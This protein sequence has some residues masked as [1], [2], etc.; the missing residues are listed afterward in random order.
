MNMFTFTITLIS[1]FF[2][3]FLAGVYFLKPSLSNIDNKIYKYILIL[4]FFQITLSLIC[5]IT[6]YYL[7]YNS[8]MM[9]I[10]DISARFFCVTQ[11]M[12]YFS[13]MLY[14][15]IITST[16]D[17]KF[18]KIVIGTTKLGKRIR[19]LL[20]LV[21]LI[22]IWITPVNYA[23]NSKGILV[24]D[25]GRTIIMFYTLIATVPI[26]VAYLVKQRKHY[27]IKKIIPFIIIIGFQLSAFGISKIDNSINMYP[28]TITL[29]SYLMFHTI[30]NPD[31]QLITK[32]QEAKDKAE[33]S[34]KEKTDFLASMSHEL[35]TP[36]N[37]IIGL[38]SMIVESNDKEQ[39]INDGKDVLK[40]ANNLQ[41]L[42]DG[43]LD[44]NNLEADNLVLEEEIYRP[45]FLFEDLIR[46]TNI[47]L[48]DKDIQLR[49]N[50]SSRIPSKLYGDREKLKRVINNLLTNAVKY[51]EKGYVDFNIDCENIN[52]I[53]NLKI[54]VRDTG[55]GIQE[56][57]K[58][59]LFQKF[60]RLESDKDSDISGTGLGLAVTKS[61]LDIMNGEIEV[62][63][64]FGQG[65]TFTIHLSQKIEEKEE[66]IEIL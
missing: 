31:I 55:R 13:L 34:N 56:D 66:E 44:I 33:K 20:I 12:W 18:R 51:T 4:D 60:Y 5:L 17:S 8:I 23:I 41:E 21:L 6:A 1:I 40:A 54:T 24:Y 32:L 47:K 30:E 16:V 48:V 53:C 39:I 38:T 10:Y 14:T 26:E 57:Q 64:I 3:A 7:N 25:G 43:M 52:D 61:L 50:F 62:D 15:L 35:R 19:L 65:T 63:S 46:I 49:T 45:K 29:I 36:L 22:V 27:E 2:W 58:Q 11:M 28:L 9:Y 59:Y 37:G 42:V